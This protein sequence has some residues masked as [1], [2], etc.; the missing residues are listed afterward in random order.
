MTGSGAVGGV[1]SSQISHSL[2]QKSQDN[3]PPHFLVPA[4]LSQ[5]G[6]DLRQ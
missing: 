2:I 1:P 4:F 6:Q 3:A 5:S